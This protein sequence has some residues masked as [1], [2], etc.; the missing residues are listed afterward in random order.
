MKGRSAW[1]VAKGEHWKVMSNWFDAALGKLIG[2]V[3]A[4][5]NQTEK[6]WILADFDS[7]RSKITEL[8]QKK[9]VY[10]NYIPFKLAILC[11]PDQNSAREG[12]RVCVQQFVAGASGDSERLSYCAV[13][14]TI[15]SQYIGCLCIKNV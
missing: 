15:D 9:F 11:D 8:L 12:F 7:G 1:R 4:L 13:L 5:T 14:H 3:S 10:T 6:S 2:V